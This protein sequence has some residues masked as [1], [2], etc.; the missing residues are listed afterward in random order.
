MPPRVSNIHLE[1]TRSERLG[2]LSHECVR[3]KE[4]MTG[5]LAIATPAAQVHEVIQLMESLD[6]SLVVVL[7]GP[8]LL[9]TISERDLALACPQADTPIAALLPPSARVCREDDVVAEAY[10]A[11]RR[12]GQTSLAVLTSDGRISGALSRAAALAVQQLR[13]GTD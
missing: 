13:Q 1:S 4:V 8:L 12:S 7:E 9:G 5:A 2:L 6:T 10:A 3:V 11:M